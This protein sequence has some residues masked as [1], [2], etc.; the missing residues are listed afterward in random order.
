[1][2]GFSVVV[3]D[4]RCEGAKD[5]IEACEPR[6]FAMRPPDPSASFLVKLKVKFHGGKQAYARN[7]D[8]CTGCMKCVEVCPEKAISVTPR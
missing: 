6:V 3:N 2:A 4:K 8:A 7:E 1:M 5:C